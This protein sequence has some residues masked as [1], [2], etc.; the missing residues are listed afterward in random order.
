M[1]KFN[2]TRPWNHWHKSPFSLKPIMSKIL[3][4]FK[5][6]THFTRI[7]A[8]ESLN[9]FVSID[10]C[11]TLKKWTGITT[12]HCQKR[13]TSNLFK[14]SANFENEMCDKLI[15]PQACDSWSIKMYLIISCQK[16]TEIFTVSSS[17]ICKLWRTIP[18][19][20][21]KET[22]QIC[23]LNVTIDGQSSYYFI[24]WNKGHSAVHA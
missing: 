8:T 3:V 1:S 16:R 22:P 4:I 15:S 18:N 14:F 11:F 2:E 9:K 21:R 20:K 6:D 10:M 7:W 5:S 13:L 24:I 17:W 19:Y 12:H 23:P